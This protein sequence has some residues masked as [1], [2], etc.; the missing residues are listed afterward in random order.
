MCNFAAAQN[1]YWIT[2]K[3]F[4]LPTHDDFR[5]NEHITTLDSVLSNCRLFF[6]LPCN[7]KSKVTER[8]KEVL[9]YSQVQPAWHKCLLR[10][11]F[12]QFQH[13]FAFYLTNV[14]V[15]K[16]DEE[17]LSE[18]QVVGQ[19]LHGDFWLQ[20]TKTRSWGLRGGGSKTKLGFLF[21]HKQVRGWAKLWGLRWMQESQNQM[22]IWRLWCTLEMPTPI[23][24]YHKAS[25]NEK[26]CTLRWMGVSRKAKQGLSSS[27]AGNRPCKMPTTVGM[28][29]KAPASQLTPRASS[30]GTTLQTT[31]FWPDRWIQVIKDKKKWEK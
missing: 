11:P 10:S 18:L 20:D 30:Q 22:W 21:L 26:L 17:W 29:L 5:P 13:F 8:N 25:L 7:A 6:S 12:C 1:T 9:A 15:A 3:W 16:E 4:G 23:H 24:A 2:A 27:H 19:I 31:D 14:T 28:G